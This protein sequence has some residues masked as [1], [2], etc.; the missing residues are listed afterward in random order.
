MSSWL[1]NILILS[2]LF[3]DELISKIQVKDMP[4]QINTLQDLYES[5]LKLLSKI[6]AIANIDNT[7][8]QYKLLNNSLPYSEDIE[9]YVNI[10]TGKYALI[11][12]EILIKQNIVNITK[13]KKTL[14]EKSAFRFV[15]QNFDTRL[16]AIAWSKAL[17]SGFRRSLNTR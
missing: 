4:K 10:T 2:N 1:L 12:F 13:Y 17:D 8:I 9:T 14:R 5:K 6:P 7:S 16:V 15:D 3:S 11:N